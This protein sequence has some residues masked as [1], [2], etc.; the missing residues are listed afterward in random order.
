MSPYNIARAL[1]T[2]FEVLSV[3]QDVFAKASALI[4]KA[5]AEGRDITETEL[6]V[7]TAERG[8]ALS[9]FRATIGE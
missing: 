7:L 1:A 8:A 3:A 5:R 4:A 6:A 9:Q 2:A